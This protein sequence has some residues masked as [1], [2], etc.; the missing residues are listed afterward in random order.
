MSTSQNQP[1]CTFCGK[2][3]QPP[4]Q[5][6]RSKFNNAIICENCIGSSLEAIKKSKSRKERKG[7]KKLVPE[8]IKEELDKYVI[9]QDDAKVSLAIAV[10]NHYKR[11]SL[12]SDVKIAKSNILMIGPTGS[13]KTLLA[14]TIAELLDVP[15]VIADCTSLTEA[16]FV[17]DDVESILLKLILAA[18]EDVER[19]EHGIIFLDEVDKLAKCGVGAGLTKDPSGEGVQQA[20]LKLIEGTVANVPPHTGRKHPMD[21]CLQFNTENVLFICGGAFP[22]LEDIINKRIGKT[23]RG[24]GF[25]A[26]VAKEEKKPVGEALRELE[27]EDLLKFGLIPEFVGRLPVVVTLDELDEDTM[28]DIL[29]KPGNSIVSQY[30]ELMKYDGVDLVFTDEALRE[31]ARETLRKKTGARGLRSI[32]EKLLK[33]PMYRLPSDSRACKCIVEG[34]NNV[35]VERIRDCAAC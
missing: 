16:G 18:D 28:V 24:M 9:G 30:R 34:L 33:D 8:R 15:F 13:G 17:G 1:V 11:L 5:G 35:R 12:Q 3:I 32:V 26:E 4:T 20:L 21:Q 27:T 10:Y 29:V 31:I 14:Q 7:G 22:G 19:A 6:I 23:N 25:G 2:R